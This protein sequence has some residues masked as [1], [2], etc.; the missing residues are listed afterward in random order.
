MATKY[1]LKL[2]KY[3]QSGDID[4]QYHPLRNI[5]GRNGIIKN[6]VIKNNTSGFNFNLENPV[7]IECQQAYDGTVNLIIN[8]GINSPKLVNSRWSNTGNDTYRIINREQ[9]NQTNIYREDLISSET[10]LFRSVRGVTKINLL[11]VMYSGKLKAGNYIF[12]LKYMDEDYN[13]TD[14]VAQSG[15]VSIFNG[16]II[17]PHTVSGGIM[18]EE[19]D[20]S[21]SLHIKDIDTSF[22]YLKLYVYRTTCDSNGVKLSYSYKIDTDYNIDGK[23]KIININGFEPTIDI[24]IEELNIDYLKVD[25]IK[26]QAQVQNMLFFANVTKTKEYDSDLQLMSLYVKAQEVLGDNIGYVNPA[27]Y[28]RRSNDDIHKVE[29]YSPLNIYYKLGYWPD[30]IYRFGIVYIY[31]NDKTS[32]VYNLRGCRFTDDRDINIKEGDFNGKYEEYIGIEKTDRFPFK[33]QMLN[34]NDYINTGGVFQ[35][36]KNLFN[37]VLNDDSGITPIG[38][39]FSVN[40]K[41]IKDL[42]KKGIKGF[43]FVRQERIPTILCQGYSVGVN[44]VGYFPMLKYKDY[45]VTESFAD[46]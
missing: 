21:I 20:K 2:K 6:F 17:S 8:D 30:E 35:F 45:Y 9:I 28:Q 18:D 29:Y 23:T 14:V 13:E 5:K 15:V 43:F 1:N 7:D 19:T 25:A 26:S 31:D 12:Y 36:N 3:K 22:S 33:A 11:D 38:I 44:K 34:N 37:R 41:F 42:H 24:S 10:S 39:Q 40:E 46:S 16:T 4:W 27:S 32:P